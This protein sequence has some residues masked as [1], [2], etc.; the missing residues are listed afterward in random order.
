MA[1]FVEAE[2]DRT[3]G[4]MVLSSYFSTRGISIIL[5]PREEMCVITCDYMVLRMTSHFRGQLISISERVCVGMF[6]GPVSAT[7]HHLLRSIREDV[8]PAVQPYE[9]KQGVEMHN[10][11]SYHAKT[12]GSHLLMCWVTARR[13]CHLFFDLSGPSC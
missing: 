9:M 8:W 2:E 3:N 10:P 1:F 6:S 4:H 12:R 7:V 13:Q 5:M 11:S